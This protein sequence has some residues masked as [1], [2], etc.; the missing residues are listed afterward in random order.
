MASSECE[1]GP[2]VVVQRRGAVGYVRLNR[3]EVYHAFNEEMIAALTQAAEELDADPE[4]RAVVLLSDGKCFCA[5]G[6]IDYMRRTGAYTREENIEDA[7]RMSGM[8]RA[9]D[10]MSKPVLCRVQGP[11][12]GGGVGLAAVAD[13]VFVGPKAFFS[14]SEVRLGIVPAVIGPYVARRVGIT[15][16]RGLFATAMRVPGRDAV[17]TGLADILCKTEEELDERIDK[18]LKSALACGPEAMAIARQIPDQVFGKDTG[19]VMLEMATLSADRRASAEGQEGLKAF[20]EKRSASY[21]M[22]LPDWDA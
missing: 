19:E 17:H 18:A 16:A 7:M 11:T 12:F 6:D 3:P 22:D 5:G 13:L 4:V 9:Y 20:L 21:Q 10:T 14:L 2:P 1:N 15:T 8:F